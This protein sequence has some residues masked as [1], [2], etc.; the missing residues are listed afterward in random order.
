MHLTRARSQ[1]KAGAGGLQRLASHAADLIGEELNYNVAV[2][3]CADLGLGE[4][5]F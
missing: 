4:P 3:P 1:L 5:I 2:K